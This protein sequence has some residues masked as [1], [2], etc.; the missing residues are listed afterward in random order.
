[1]SPQ[2]EK[3]P[4]DFMEGADVS[5]GALARSQQEVQ[6]C[7]NTNNYGIS[8]TNDGKLSIPRIEN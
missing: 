6:L 5:L 1:M 8:S 2:T 3:V 4:R 7:L